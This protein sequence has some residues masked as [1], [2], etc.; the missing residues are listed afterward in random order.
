MGFADN[1]KLNIIYY[2]LNIEINNKWLSSTFNL[3]KP[4]I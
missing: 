4:T 3:F 1:F 2:K